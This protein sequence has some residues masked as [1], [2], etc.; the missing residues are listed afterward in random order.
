ME[1]PGVKNSQIH[2]HGMTQPQTFSVGVSGL[3]F[4]VFP[5]PTP[6]K[7]FIPVFFSQ[8]LVPQEN[9]GWVLGLVR[10]I[11]FVQLQTRDCSPGILGM[12]GG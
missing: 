11:G 7:T 10:G 6:G 9:S 3:Q 4:Q 2:P 12:G 1:T 8:I 5:I